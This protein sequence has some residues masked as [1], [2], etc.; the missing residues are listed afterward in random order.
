VVVA[1]GSMKPQTTGAKPEG[2][3]ASK[4]FIHEKRTKLEN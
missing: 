3:E 1:V 2:G 4:E